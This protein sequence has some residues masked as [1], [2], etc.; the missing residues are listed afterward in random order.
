MDQ[1][2]IVTKVNAGATAVTIEINC[3]TDFVAR[4]EDFI[5]FEI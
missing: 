3:E 1:G 5:S 2:L 4:N